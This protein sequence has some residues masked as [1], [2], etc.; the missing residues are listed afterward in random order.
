MRHRTLLPLIGVLYTFTSHWCPENYDTHIVASLQ[1]T[2]FMWEIVGTTGLASPHLISLLSL[3][4]CDCFINWARTILHHLT[5]K[6]LSSFLSLG[7]MNITILPKNPV[8]S[9]GHTTQLV[10]LTKGE[11][12]VLAI[13]HFSYSY[14]LNP[15][16]W[17]IHSQCTL[18]ASHENVIWHVYWEGHIITF[19]TLVQFLVGFII[20]FSHMLLLKS[21]HAQL[22]LRHNCLLIFST[23]YHC[24]IIII[25]MLQL[26]L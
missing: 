4:S 17:H 20:S 18:L 10:C 25:V 19:F 12:H 1:Y 24:I 16:A 14:W 6:P 15:M 26:V 11:L 8:I 23:R 9:K 2:L 5:N 7:N 3:L 13:L 21:I 22:T